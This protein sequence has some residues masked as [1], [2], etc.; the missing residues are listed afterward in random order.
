MLYPHCTTLVGKW[1]LA[2]SAVSISEEGCAASGGRDENVDGQREGDYPCR[3]ELIGAGNEGIAF[4][5]RN[6]FAVLVTS[7]V[8]L[9]WLWQ[10]LR[11]F[12]G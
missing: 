6:N 12:E 10:L 11:L 4:T 8:A 1:V 3:N 7:L 2:L 9:V 5:D